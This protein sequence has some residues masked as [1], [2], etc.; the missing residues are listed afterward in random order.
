MHERGLNFQGLTKGGHGRRSRATARAAV[1]C[2]ASLLALS[3]PARAIQGNQADIPETAPA[4]VTAPLVVDGRELLRVRGVSALPAEQRAELIAGRIRAVAADRSITVNDVSLVDMGDQTRVH[5]RDRLIMSI[6]DAD[7]G[8]EGIPRRVLSEIYLEKIKSAIELHRHERTS[9]F[10]L[11][12]SSY[13]VGA[14]LLLAVIIFGIIRMCRRL[15]QTLERRYRSKIGGLRI[16]SFQLVAAENLWLTV[17]RAVHAVRALALLVAFLIFTNY[18]GGLYPWTRALS[19]R[20]LALLLDPLQTMASSILGSVPDLAFIAVLIVIVRYILKL[21]SLF[22]TGVHHGAVTLSGFDRDWALP[23]YK[24][25]RMLIIAFAVVVAYPY[26]PGS[27]SEAFKGVSIFVGIV[28]SLGSTSAIANIIAGYMMTY[29]RAYKVGDRIK[30]MDL[31][32]DVVEIRLQVTHLRSV[33]NEEIILPNSSIL[34]SH[35]VNYSRLAKEGGLILHT[36]VGIGYETPWRQVESMLQMAAERT[37]GLLRE[38]PPFVLQK[39]LGDFAVTYEINVY[40]DRPQN[41]LALYTMLHRNILDVF[42][43]Y[44]V[45]IM[46]PAYEG[47]PEIAKVVPKEKWFEMPAKVYRSGSAVE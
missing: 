45:Q 4:Q 46:T 28:F 35:V 13:A 6:T 47:D 7:A 11:I 36:T 27:R 30:V 33:K 3:T 19:G 37:D 14:T 22:F 43:E 38:P 26:F 5:A 44:G 8:I 42:N 17:H 10:L 12:N 1:M 32:G 20:G 18:V 29:R 41:S 15:E 34:N 25:F 39:E 31:I 23:T 40:C 9:R 21:A 16:Q 24:I 2:I